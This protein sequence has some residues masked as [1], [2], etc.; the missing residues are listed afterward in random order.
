[1]AKYNKIHLREYIPVDI[2]RANGRKIGFTSGAFDILH[3]S[4]VNLFKNAKEVCDIL[5]V[6]VNSDSSIKRYKSVNRPIISEDDRVALVAAI[7]YVDFVFVFDEESNTNNINILKPDFYIKGYDYKNKSLKSR[8]LVESYG[9]KV[10]LID[11]GTKT[12]TDIID[13]IITKELSC[14]LSDRLTYGGLVILD[15]DGVVIEDNGYFKDVNNIRYIDGSLEAIRL[16]NEHN[17]GV[18]ITTNQPAIG[19]GLNTEED[20]YATT[21]KIIKDVHAAKA[22]IDRVYFCPDISGKSYY[23]KPN[24]GMISKALIDFPVLPGDKVYMIGD[25]R[26]DSLA[27]K[28]ADPSIVTI[29]VDTGFALKDTW[30]NHLPDLWTN[31]LLEAVNEWILK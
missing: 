21:S 29:G 14:R 8:E 22:R 28:N 12:T 2:Y 17:I 7:E 10:I 11:N 19:V 30:V 18:V 23:K 26:S 3:A 6:G 9:G 20:Y 31:N 13:K 16:L 25:R 27:A 4:H 5:V 1:M 15:R 24:G